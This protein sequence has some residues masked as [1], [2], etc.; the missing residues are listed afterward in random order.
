M[1]GLVKA[2]IS[3]VEVYIIIA[4]Y[5]LR[6]QHKMIS[7]LTDSQC[8]LLE[9]G[10][11]EDIEPRKL[12]AYL[13]LHMGL[14]SA[15]ASALKIADINFVNGTLTVSRVLTR[16]PNDTSICTSKD[17]AR[18]EKWSYMVVP[19]GTF[20]RSVPMPPHVYRL[21]HDNAGLYPDESRFLIS[22]ETEL[23]R[24]YYLQ[25]VLTSIGLKYGIAS[26]ITPIML[27]N[28]FIRRCLEN[29]VDLCTLGA[30]LGIQHLDEITKKY[31]EY[32]TPNQK[33]INVLEKFSSG[34]VEKK[35]PE[36]KSPSLLILGCGSHG[37]TI[38]ETAEAIGIFPKIAFLDDDINNPEAIDVITRLEDYVDEYPLAFIAIGNNA[39]RKTLMERLKKAGFVLPYLCDP[40]ANVSTTAKLC[41]GSYVGARTIIGAQ[42]VIHEG[43]IIA[44]GANLLNNVVAEAYCHVD[45]GATIKK[46]VVIP[47]LAKIESGSVVGIE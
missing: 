1:S 2:I 17:A 19:A 4:Y 35:K 14:S 8:V 24:S 27:R 26:G 10:L 18:G 29:G 15:E 16:K 3:D 30:V 20:E 31:K 5:G 21:L 13:C 41:A 23:P 40:S 37:H 47:T 9:K 22:A 46:N 36:Y 34:Y 7:M 25:N 39:I 6:G 42:T 32:I 45:S 44:S 43:A 12:A 28:V 33:A 11:T 38:K